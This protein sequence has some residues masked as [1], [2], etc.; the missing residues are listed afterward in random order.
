MQIDKEVVK[1][2]GT[3]S[4]SFIPAAFNEYSMFQLGSSLSFRALGCVSPDD[5]VN[6]NMHDGQY[7]CG[8]LCVGN[9]VDQHR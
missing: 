6:S 5:D 4:F 8:G 9:K 1:H 2:D 3:K 7:A